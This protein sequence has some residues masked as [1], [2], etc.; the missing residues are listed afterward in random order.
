MT[1]LSNERLAE[2]IRGWHNVAALDAGA[3]DVLAALRELQSA[4]ERMAGLRKALESKAFHHGTWP[5]VAHIEYCD[6]CHYAREHIRKYGH[7]ASCPLAI[8]AALAAQ[9]GEG[10]T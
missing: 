3:K 7:G 8:L 1:P 6:F 10:E 4:R 2:L 5:E 9:S